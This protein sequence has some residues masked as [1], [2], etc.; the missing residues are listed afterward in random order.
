[1]E[2]GFGNKEMSAVESGLAKERGD[3]ERERGGEK[4]KRER[5]GE[6]R[7]RGRERERYTERGIQREG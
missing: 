4:R 2:D 6:R 5:E 7:E 1:M 3:R